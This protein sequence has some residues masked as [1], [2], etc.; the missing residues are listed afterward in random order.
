MVQQDQEHFDV[1][2]RATNHEAERKFGPSRIVHQGRNNRDGSFSTRGIW[3]LDKPPAA[4][5][6][7]S[8]R[9]TDPGWSRLGGGASVRFGSTGDEQRSF[10][11]PRIVMR[12]QQRWQ[13]LGGP[14]NGTDQA[15]NWREARMS[16]PARDA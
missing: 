3:R 4:K 5:G 15:Q 2:V 16:V 6:L 12:R 11:S 13:E 1:C 7:W 14:K 8:G 9:A 10:R